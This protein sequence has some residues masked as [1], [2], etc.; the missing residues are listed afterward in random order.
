MPAKLTCLSCLGFIVGRLGCLSTRANW[1][2]FDAMLLSVSF[3]RRQGDI[4]H[5]LSPSSSGAGSGA[6]AVPASRQNLNPGSGIYTT[7][8]SYVFE[9]HDSADKGNVVHLPW[10]STTSV[11][12]PARITRQLL[13][14]Q[15][16]AKLCSTRVIK[17]L[18]I[19]VIY[20]LERLGP[21]CICRIVVTIQ[22]GACGTG[23]LGEGHGRGPT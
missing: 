4:N 22:P 19:C 18:F 17:L 10:N 5:L 20:D 13:S 21:G 12:V 14:T 1:N 3:A 9:H 8:C 2:E 7:M 23:L 16:G 6:P 15:Q 11:R